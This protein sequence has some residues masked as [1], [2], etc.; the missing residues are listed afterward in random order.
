MAKRDEMFLS[1]AYDDVN[2][3]YYDDKTE[4]LYI[5]GTNPFDYKDIQA[6]I[7]IPFGTLST[8]DRYKQMEQLI[9]LYNP[10]HLVGHSLG[11]SEV[12]EYQKYNP[13]ISVRTY[14]APVMSITP[15]ER[16]RHNWDPI[17]MLDWGAQSSSSSGWNPH[18]YSGFR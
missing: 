10:K 13:Q 5:S 12:L 17:S 7:N 3:H 18:S 9:Q 4:T 2:H 1:R 6:D 15:G 11:G 8:T 14:G 16:Y